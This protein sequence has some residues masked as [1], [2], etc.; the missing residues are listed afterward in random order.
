MS[1]AHTPPVA[2]VFTRDREGIRTF[3]QGVLGLPLREIGEFADV[4]NLNGATLRIVPI[5]D[6][7]PSPHTVLGWDVDDIQQPAR[8]LISKGVQMQI[9]DGFDQDD[10]GIWSAPDR[11]AKVAWFLDPEGNNLS[12]S[13]H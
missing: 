11:S 13:Q 10:L 9:Y 1:L 8:M 2:F 4:F 7:V 3:Y 6:H 12:I 5:P